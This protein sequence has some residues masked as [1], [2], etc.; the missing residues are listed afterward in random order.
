MF[1]FP[2]SPHH[3]PLLPLSFSLLSFSLL[4]PSSSALLPSLQQRLKTDEYRSVPS[5]IS[6][7]Q[8]LLENAKKFYKKGSEE[9]QNAEELERAFLERLQECWEEASEGGGSRRGGEVV[10]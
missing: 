1:I 7:V 6:D 5:F 3:F 4:S 9:L 8:L 10:A 2:I